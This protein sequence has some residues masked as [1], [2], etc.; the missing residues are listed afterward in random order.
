M[1]VLLSPP[2][3]FTD[4]PPPAHRR[5]NPAQIAGNCH[6]QSAPYHSLCVYRRRRQ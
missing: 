4:I 1:S 2:G 5:V 6:W 3:L